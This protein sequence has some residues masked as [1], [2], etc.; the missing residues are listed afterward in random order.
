MTKT[1]EGPV[2]LIFELRGYLVMLASDVA[3]IFDVETRL[4]NQNIKANNKNDP[5]LFPEKYA[6][7]LTDEET[8]CL[9]S[10]GMISKLTRGGSRAT[11]WVVTRKGAIRLAT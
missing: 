2:S 4:L 5:P 3:K 6:F 9:R 10:S 11:P 8:E 7:Q 1:K